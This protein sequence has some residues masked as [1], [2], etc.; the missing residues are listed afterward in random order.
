LLRSEI[1]G[2][3]LRQCSRCGGAWLGREAFEHLVEGR[4]ERATFLDALPEPAAQAPVQGALEFSY[5]PCPS[6]S[7]LMNRSNYARVSG[8]IVDSCRDHGIWFDRDE[9]RRVLAFIEN[10]G[11]K[12]AM[13]HEQAELKAERDRL[14]EAMAEARQGGESIELGS[15]L[16]GRSDHSGAGLLLG[17]ILVGAA[18]T[19][20]GQLRR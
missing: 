20:W 12:R 10:G 15:V 18:A 4:E 16:G 9:L 8:V 6:C 1:G 13:Q 17:E 2:A 14:K 11:Q 3:V 7:R 19:L 5:R